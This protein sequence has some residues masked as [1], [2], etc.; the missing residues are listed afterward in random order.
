MSDIPAVIE[1]I[2]RMDSP[3]DRAGEIIRL[4]RDRTKRKT[5][6]SS[7]KSAV[8]L[9]LHRYGYTYKEVGLMTNC[10]YS[11][12]MHR[13]KVG[14]NLEDTSYPDYQSVSD[15]VDKYSFLIHFQ[16]KKFLREWEPGVESVKVLQP[17]GELKEMWMPALGG[18]IVI[19]GKG[20]CAEKRVAQRRAK[21]IR[22]EFAHGQ[23]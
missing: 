2:E 3:E 9:Q 14:R 12:A 21:A 20:P 23:P 7:F 19:D 15:L 17:D 4:V 11:T 6:I 10:D 8:S 5:S 18:K 1:Q 16:L 13:V 22:E